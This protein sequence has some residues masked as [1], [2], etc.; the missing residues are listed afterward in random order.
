MPRN[1]AHIEAKIICLKEAPA[2]GAKAYFTADAKITTVAG[3]VQIGRF[4]SAKDA[5]DY[6]KVEINIV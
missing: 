5:D 4:L 3:S 1:G 6:A 2:A